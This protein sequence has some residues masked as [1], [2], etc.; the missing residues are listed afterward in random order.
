MHEQIQNIAREFKKLACGKNDKENQIMD[1]EE[2]TSDYQL[3]IVIHSMD[4]G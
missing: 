2:D 4:A 3:H 1:G